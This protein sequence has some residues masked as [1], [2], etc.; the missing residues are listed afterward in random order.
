MTEAQARQE[1]SAAQLNMEQAF[2][3]LNKAKQTLESITG[4]KA[5]VNSKLIQSFSHAAKAD[6][7][8]VQAEF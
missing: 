5:Y 4:C 7:G 3:A 6:D 8:Y 2:A 1:F